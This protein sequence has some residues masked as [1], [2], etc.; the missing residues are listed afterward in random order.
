MPFSAKKNPSPGQSGLITPTP[1]A[2]SAPRCDCLHLPPARPAMLHASLPW[3]SCCH[4]RAPHERQCGTAAGG[5]P[6]RLPAA[7]RGSPP[8]PTTVL[9]HQASARVGATTPAVSQ[10]RAKPGR[11]GEQ[12]RLSRRPDE[13][14]GSGITEAAARPPRSGEE[15]GPH[16]ALPAKPPSS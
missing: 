4:N 2:G 7:G 8:L 11:D 15:P 9:P 10:I 1:P 6:A 13:N 14:G 12:S 3:Q 16:P 5:R